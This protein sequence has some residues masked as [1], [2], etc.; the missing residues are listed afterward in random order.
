MTV[1]KLCLETCVL[2]VVGSNNGHICLLCV[3]SYLKELFGRGQ[4]YTFPF[5]FFCRNKGDNC[6]LAVLYRDTLDP[7]AIKMTSLNLIQ[8][9]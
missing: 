8:N 5:F 2:R 3:T 6:L 1:V 9:H 7:N 4:S